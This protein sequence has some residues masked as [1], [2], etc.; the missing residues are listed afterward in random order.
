MKKQLVLSLAILS[1]L[2][3]T[4]TSSAV[5][6][7]TPL[8][9]CNNNEEKIFIS[10]AYQPAEGSDLIARGWW[11]LDANSCRDI[12]FPVTGDK[13]LVHAQSSSQIYHWLGDVKLCVNTVDAYDLEGA[14]TLACNQPGQEQRAFKQ[15]SLADLRATSEGEIPKIDFNPNDATRVGGGVK[16]CNDTTEEIYISYAQKKTADVNTTVNGWFLAKP[17]QC[18]EANREKEADEVLFF[19]N[20]QSGM[21]KW[22]GDLTM[23]TNDFDGFSH[24]EA[25]SMS[26]DATN[27]KLQKFKKEKL[28][29]S[30]EYVHLFKLADAHEARSLVEICNKSTEEIAFVIGMK[31]QEFDQT[32]SRGWYIV[33]AGECIKDQVIDAESVLLHVE[34]AD[35][36]VLV[37]GDYQVCVDDEKAFQYSQATSMACTGADDKKVGFSEVKIE[38]G[39]VRIDI[40]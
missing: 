1:G 36:T 8:I 38:A 2:I 4:A 19:A 12:S 32:I 13:I 11:G 35:R 33:K 6:T 26:C 9:F 24:K 25:Q 31:D 30:G 39:K 14:A 27:L 23:C 18:F 34:K 5:S 29:I 10:V 17:G 3:G 20:S 22:A 16:F 28:P 37:Q 40:P 21:R 15:L 7:D